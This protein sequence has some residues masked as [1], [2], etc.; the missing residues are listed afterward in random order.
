MASY[1]VRPNSFMI[2]FST[3]VYSSYG[4]LASTIEK[5][6]SSMMVEVEACFLV[7]SACTLLDD[8]FIGGCSVE[9]N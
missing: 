9:L 6:L 7:D 5:K 3:V 2:E 1:S 4:F 8:L